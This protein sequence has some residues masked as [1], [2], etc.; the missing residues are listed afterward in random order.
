M[1]FQTTD[2]PP[3]V[4]SYPFVKLTEVEQDNLL[5]PL[6]EQEIGFILNCMG[7]NKSPVPDGLTT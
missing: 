7:K 4:R 1:L 3:V 2:P 6:T 5:A